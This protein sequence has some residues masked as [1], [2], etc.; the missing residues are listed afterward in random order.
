MKKLIGIII[1]AVMLMASNALAAGSCTQSAKSYTGGAFIVTLVCTGDS[2]SGS[3]PAINIAASYM[4]VVE[5]TH[6]LY[7]VNAYPTADGTAPD[8]ADVSVTMA[9]EDLLGGKGANLIHATAKQGTIPYSTFMTNYRYP[10]ITG[11]LAVAVAN[12][13]TESANYTVELIFVR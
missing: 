4:A 6:Y 5:G 1:L 12:Q 10:I 3:I 7:L 11:Q 9:G 2:S 8:A 13:A